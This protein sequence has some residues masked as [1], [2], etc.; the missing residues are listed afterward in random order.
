MKGVFE[1]FENPE[2][3][4]TLQSPPYAALS[5]PASSIRTRPSFSVRSTLLFNSHSISLPE[6]RATSTRFSSA[7]SSVDTGS[8]LLILILHLLNSHFPHLKYTFFYIYFL[9]PCVQLRPLNWTLCQ[10]SARSFQILSSSMISKSN[11][12]CSFPIAMQFEWMFLPFDEESLFF[13]FF[14]CLGFLQQLLLSVP[15]FSWV[16][17]AFQTPFSG[18]AVSSLRSKLN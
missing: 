12:H 17:V 14:Y 4:V 8:A 3:S 9:V 7:A 16:Y 1:L 5:S 13:F 6:I 2:M 15:R 10:P 11:T 18:S